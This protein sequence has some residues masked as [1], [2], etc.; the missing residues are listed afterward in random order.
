MRLVVLC[1]WWLLACA[2]TATPPEPEVPDAAADPVEILGDVQ[3]LL[4]QAVAESNA[5]NRGEAERRWLAAVALMDAHLL[6]TVRAQDP[7]K[8]LALEYALGRMGAALRGESGRPTQQYKALDTT[9]ADLR[10]MFV[11]MR[12]AQAQAVQS[13]ADPAEAKAVHPVEP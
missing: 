7:S 13:E 9:L 3:H 5:H 6:D 11:A 8:A 1:A 2:P 10:P 12:D 4:G